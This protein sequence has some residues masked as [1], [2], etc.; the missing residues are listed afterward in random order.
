MNLNK[1]EEIYHTQLMSGQRT[2]VLNIAAFKE[3]LKIAKRSKGYEEWLRKIVDHS[4]V[5]FQGELARKALEGN[6]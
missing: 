6:E 1:I 3:L 5:S 4:S 2:I